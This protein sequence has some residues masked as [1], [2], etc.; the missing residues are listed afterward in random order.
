MEREKK[1]LRK[2]RK[3]IKSASGLLID[4]IIILLKGFITSSMSMTLR[5]SSW[6]AGSA[7]GKS[8]SPGWRKS[9]E[10]S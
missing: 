10:R 3:E 1:S 5:S 2:Q 9:L 8:L 6:E 4:F 7:A